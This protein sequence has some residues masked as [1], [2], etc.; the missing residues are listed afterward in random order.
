MANRKK[1]SRRTF[2]RGTGAVLV[3]AIAGGTWRACDQ[4]VFSTGEGP[5][6]EPWEQWRGEDQQG[7]LALVSAAILA[8]NPHNTQPWLFRVSEDRIDLFAHKERNLGPIDPLLREMHTGLGCALEHLHTGQA[9]D[10]PGC[11][12][13]H[14]G[15]FFRK[16]PC[17]G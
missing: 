3:V 8:A 12:R 7:P 1:V 13:E 11:M 4:G 15:R 16:R 6:F 17:R 2:L 10:E 5:A 14:V 9:Q